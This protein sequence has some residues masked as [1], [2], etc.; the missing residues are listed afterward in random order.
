MIRTCPYHIVSKRIMS[1]VGPP[2][3]LDW[4][5]P[6]HI[7]LHAWPNHIDHQFVHPG[8]KIRSA[9]CFSEYWNFAKDLA[10]IHEG[11]CVKPRGRPDSRLYNG[12]LQHNILYSFEMFG[13][14]GKC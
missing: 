4:N 10:L 6:W 11:D 3:D 2:P 9:K 14:I 12:K 5:Q 13:A 8:F 1:F 7:I